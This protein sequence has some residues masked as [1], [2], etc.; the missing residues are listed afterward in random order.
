MLYTSDIY[1]CGYPTREKLE[2]LWKQSY[3]KT[4]VR[5]AVDELISTEVSTIFILMIFENSMVFSEG[6]LG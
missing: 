2:E 1:R 4:N 5:E 6:T 3:S